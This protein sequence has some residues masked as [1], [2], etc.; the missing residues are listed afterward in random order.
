[1]K[2][3][4]NDPRRVVRE[5]LEGLVD[6]N[7]ELAI[8]SEENVILRADIPQEPK[9]RAVALV[10]GGGSGHEPAHAGFVG[11]GMLTSA[12][13]GDVFTSPSV[14]AVLAA[15]RASAGPAG[16]VLIVKNYTGDRL[17]FS[18]AAEIARAEN[19][20]TEV[21]FVGD[22]VAL[23]DRLPRTQSRGIAGTVLVHKIAG[24]AVAEGKTAIEVANLARA[25]AA[26]LASMGVGLGACTV[27]AAGKP[28]FTL[29]EDEVEFG[30][31][32]HGEKGLR[33]SHVESADSIARELLN[34]ILTNYGGTE[35]P[36]GLLVN[37][38]GGT[39]PMELSIIA[40]SALAEL[41]RRGLTPQLVWTGEFM[42]ALEMPGCSL[43][44]IPLN[45]E[46]KRLLQAE[47]SARYW[48]RSASLPT[49]RYVID[50]PKPVNEEKN[51]EPSPHAK[52]MQA[53]VERVSY[54]LDAQE[55]VLTALDAAGGDGDLGASM[56]RGAQALRDLPNEAYAD[57]KALFFCMAQALRRAIAGSSGPFYAA[58]LM[59]A[60]NTLPS[61]TPNAEEWAAAFIAASDSVQKIGGA[62]VGDRTMVDALEP[63]ARAFEEAIEAGALPQKALESASSAADAGAHA[64]KTMQPKFGR[65]AYLGER[66]VG[67]VDGGAMA[68]SIW[69]T[70][71][72]EGLAG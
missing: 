62:K 44:L 42:T 19:I 3:L 50:A 41:R 58:G 72:Q 30:L 37:G 57:P 40:R 60:S 7:P 8:L 16:A 38:L 21:V 63:A 66:A 70:A 31:G 43:T 71:L 35:L 15:L 51:Y 47:T 36:V 29:E 67:T 13:A 1:M 48:P 53:I 26:D 64:T 23:R 9:Q 69:M 11:Y 59:R 2:K 10:S 34:T 45:E 5:L 56:Q 32:I 55:Q 52:L 18:L 20:P 27:P 6:C 28:G 68:V 14:D 65:A 4:V 22:D 46:R 33:R 54:E 17:N 39:P 24:A 61:G 49:H 12:I 25:V